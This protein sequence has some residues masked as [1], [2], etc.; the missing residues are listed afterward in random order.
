MRVA[1][2]AT[3]GMSPPVVTAFVD[4]I[5]K[6]S[7]LVV[8]T[9]ADEK[10]KQGY[11]LVRVAMKSKYPG[12][13]IHEVEIPFEDVTTEEQNF[14]FM[15]IAGKTIKDQKKK[16]GSDVVYLNVAGGRKNMCITL[17]L[18]GQFL[19]VDGIFHVVSP[20]VKIVNE[21]LENLRLDIERMYF[22]ESDEEKMEIYRE[23]E[24][25]FDALMFP[26]DY[27]VIRIPTVP[28]PEDYMMRLVDVL[29]NRKLDSLTYSDRELLL[30]HG[31]IEK[32]G[33]R[34]LVTDFGKKF[35]EVLIR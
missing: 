34:Y 1:V 35:A 27:R 30:R 20:D 28:I 6:V 15:R 3:L 18:L 16:F 17:S 7:D 13:R 9:T 24:R 26:R 29:Y 23:K 5:G 25:Y 4:Y 21:T 33:S 14:E 10:V 19:S 8:M 32:F 31:L 2:I 12:T 11:E 22:S